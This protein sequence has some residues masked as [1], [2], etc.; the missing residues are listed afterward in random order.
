M[1][2]EW[3]IDGYN[4][5]HSLAPRGNKLKTVPRE[6][7]IGLLAGFASCEE[8]QVLMVLD[9]Q[10]DDQEFR[11]YQTKNFLV[12][13]SQKLTAD[14]VIEKILFEKKGT[15]SIRVVTKDRALCLMAR[16]LGAGVMAPDEFM[17]FLR[18]DKKQDDQI[19]FK[20]KVRSHGFS[21]P[22]E[23][24]LK[25]DSTKIDPKSKKPSKDQTQ[26]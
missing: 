22:F 14:S 9:G 13:Y 21:R 26:E 3:L 18:D 12:I 11:P 5:L 6:T 25:S 19:L 16:G 10:G 1:L 7:L 15:A 17:A 8:R 4:L 24:K 20:E 2:E 23:D